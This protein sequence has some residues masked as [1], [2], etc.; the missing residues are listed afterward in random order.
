MSRLKEENLKKCFSIL[1]DF[2]EG[3]AQDD[4][5]KGTAILALNQLQKIKAGMTIHTLSCAAVPR[6]NGVP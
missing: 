4:K 3:A 1:R 2:I 5:N 6:I